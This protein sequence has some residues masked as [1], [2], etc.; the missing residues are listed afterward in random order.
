MKFKRIVHISVIFCCCTQPLS[1]FAQHQIIFCGEVIP[2]NNSIVSGKLMDVIRKQIKNI[3][4][5][6]LLK[7]ANDY[8]PYI[9]NYLQQAGLPLDLKYI[10]IVE[11]GFQNLTSSAGASGFWQLMPATAS[12]YGLSVSAVA[13][14]RNDFYKSTEAACKAIIGN[15]KY[16]RSHKISSWVLTMAAYNFGIGNISNAIKKQGNSDYFSMNLN[17]ETAA[18][19]Y[20][21]IAVKELFE[22][23][24]FYMKDFGYNIFNAAKNPPQI[25]LQN[26]QIDTTAFNSM[27]VTANENNTKQ[28]DSVNETKQQKKFVSIGANLVGKYKNFTD[29]QLISF[30]LQKDLI[31]KN[32][33]NKKG[34][35]LSGTGWLIDGRIFIDLGYEDHDVVI[36]SPE[37]GKK[38]L[39]L[40]ELKK[41]QIIIL[42]VQIDNN[43]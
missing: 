41:D 1:L 3:N 16:L 39:E 26:A 10:P 12:G 43:E 30:K 15:Y 29:G 19:V 20:K 9:E 36:K 14:D 23:P 38:G 32:T 21:I 37:T 11:S 25:N 35:V 42:S 13:D 28:S 22:Y 34:N 27:V 17:K 7:R 6:A 24:E 4:M 40:S 33:F 18:Y 2:V 8:F 5:P 31:V